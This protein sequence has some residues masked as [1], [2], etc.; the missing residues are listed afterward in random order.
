M[1]VTN[2]NIILEVT[3]QCKFWGESHTLFFM[4]SLTVNAAINYEVGKIAD[5][6][7]N[8]VLRVEVTE[9]SAIHWELEGEKR[10]HDYKALYSQ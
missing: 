9:S 8:A 2:V 10:Y 5:T 3:D 1:T 7:R 6:K 4:A